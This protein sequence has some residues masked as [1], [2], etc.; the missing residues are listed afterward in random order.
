MSSYMMKTKSRYTRAIC[1][2]PL[3]PM[4]YIKP[5]RMAVDIAFTDGNIRLE[6]RAYIAFIS[7]IA[8][9]TRVYSTSYH[10]VWDRSS[11]EE[12]YHTVLLEIYMTHM[13]S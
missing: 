2:T 11:H 10:A 6:R 7:L 1:I 8:L 3:F 4:G 13:Y 9:Y 12:A 5:I